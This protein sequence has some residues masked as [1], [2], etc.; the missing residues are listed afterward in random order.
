MYMSSDVLPFMSYQ[1]SAL[2][3]AV[4]CKPRATG[5][6]VDV[7]AWA[8]ARMNTDMQTGNKITLTGVLWDVL[9]NQSKGQDHS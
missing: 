9:A 8:I 3:L 6:A 5:G 2:T 1:C 7:N 4:R